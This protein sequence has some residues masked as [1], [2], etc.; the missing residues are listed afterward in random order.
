A[1]GT[2]MTAPLGCNDTN[3][4]MV[5]KSNS[6]LPKGNVRTSRAS[7]RAERQAHLMLDLTQRHDGARLPDAR[8]V[9]Q[10]PVQKAVVSLRAFHQNLQQ[11]VGI[12]RDRIAFEDLGRIAHR[13]LEGLDRAGRMP[14]ETDLR[15]H[16]ALQPDLGAIHLRA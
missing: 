9:E 7:S 8:Q 6:S 16:A 15:E 10:E 13:A 2:L 14:L 1:G 4:Q 11:D 3:L 12:A 5:C